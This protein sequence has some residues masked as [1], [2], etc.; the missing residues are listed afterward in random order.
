MTSI[1]K[2]DQIQ[3]AAGTAG[4]TI[5]SNGVVNLPNTIAFLAYVSSTATQG[6]GSWSHDVPFDAVEFNV[7]GCYSTSTY[8]FTP[9]TSGHYQLNASINTDMTSG[10]SG[11]FFGRWYKNGSAYSH[12]GHM[13]AYSSD[14]AII[15]GA[16]VM[17]FN[18]STDYVEVRV[19]TDGGTTLGINGGTPTSSAGM[20]THFS[21]HLIG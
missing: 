21:G 14:R 1:I 15:G 6:A 10:S 2:V 12:F 5:D 13:L 19:N 3:N 20:P 17:H 18:G 7:G 8:R 9:T 16:T 11:R 4:L